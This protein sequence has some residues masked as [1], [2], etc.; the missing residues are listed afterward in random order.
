MESSVAITE[1]D[2]S[3]GG[4]SKGSELSFKREQLHVSEQ[5]DQGQ[6]LSILLGDH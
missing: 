6:F 3:G 1:E 2:D 5:Q 4:E